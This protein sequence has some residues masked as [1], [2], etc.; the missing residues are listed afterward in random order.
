ME[1]ICEDFMAYEL[2][3]TRTVFFFNDPFPL[4]IADLALRH[5]EE[6]LDRH[7]RPAFV[8]YR[9]AGL[10]I[11]DRLD[12]SSALAPVRSTPFWHIY[13]SRRVAP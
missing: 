7:P 12:A 1:L 3:A 4:A 13:A 9:K 2:P 10:D 8:L 6:S 5:V 11:L